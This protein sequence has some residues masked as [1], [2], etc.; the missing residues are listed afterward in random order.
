MKKTLPKVLIY[1]FLLA[2]VFISIFPFYYAFVG[3]TNDSGT[4]F[5]FPDALIP[6]KLLLQNIRNLSEYMP[7]ANNL[8]NSIFV[9]VVGTTFCVLIST[10]AAYAFSKLRF[11]GSNTIFT[12][13]LLSMMLPMNVT[14]IPS[15]KI[16][17][18]LGWLNTYKA[19]I[20]PNLISV[21]AIYL[22]NQNFKA[23]PDALIEAARID[24][25]SEF[26]IFF[27]I[28]IPSM[29]SSLS[30]TCILTFMTYWNSF[31]WSKIVTNASEM[32]T[33]P[34]ALSSLINPSGGSYNAELM[35]GVSLAIIPILVV[36]LLLQKQFI[37]GMLGSAVK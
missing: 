16:I 32:Y 7:I 13:M 36:F 15:F 4:L 30:A 37:S 1:G 26:R 20:I 9:S 24:G 12:I 25:A 17:V 18:A 28:V 23:F 6:G 31:M 27:S 35:A 21:Y 33:M 22:M 19:L 11:K 10:M 29:R 5:R 34:V 14:L 2:G 3:A 8:F